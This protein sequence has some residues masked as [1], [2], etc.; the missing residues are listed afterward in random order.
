MSTYTLYHV[1]A[2]THRVFK[3]NPAAVCALNTW[4]PEATLQAIAAENNL[5]ETAFF[6]G[7][8]GRYHLRWFTPHHEVEFCGHGTLA[9]AYVIFA[10]L[11]LLSQEV[12]FETR[13]GELIARRVDNG[14]RLILPALPAVPCQMPSYFPAGLGVTPTAVYKADH[15]LVVLKEAEQLRSLR[16][17]RA[18]FAALDRRGII[19]TAPSDDPHIDIISRF[20]TPLE[21]RLEDPVTGSAHC[22]LVPYWAERLGKK[23]LQAHQLSA[24]GGEIH[25]MLNDH[26]HIELTGQVAPYLIGT[27]VIG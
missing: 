20:F 3:G 25:C 23:T 4:L 14:I 11:E 13:K 7:E 18:A 2:F 10:H 15:Y 8:E 5:S 27:I 22:T 1:D 17:N 24:R 6:I 21:P 26:H 16:I 19:V 9:A 12:V